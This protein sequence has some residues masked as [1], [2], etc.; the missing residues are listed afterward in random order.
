MQKP[1]RKGIEMIWGSNGLVGLT[2]GG[3][4][5]QDTRIENERALINSGEYFKAYWALLD[6]DDPSLPYPGPHVTNYLH[7]FNNPLKDLIRYD[8]WLQQKSLLSQ[9]DGKGQTTNYTQTPSTQMKQWLT[10]T[11]LWSVRT[12]LG[13]CISLRT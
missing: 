8:E 9:S 6:I 12:D 7:N 11:G 4:F 10:W 13:S 5:F 1:T 3:D 2:Q